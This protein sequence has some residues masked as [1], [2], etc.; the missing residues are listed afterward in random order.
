MSRRPRVRLHV[1]PFKKTYLEPVKIPDWHHIYADPSRP[2][3]VDLGSARGRFLW[4]MAQERPEWNY[5]GLEIRK[6]LIEEANAWRD[7]DQLTNLHYLFCNVTHALDE[8]LAS[9]PEGTLREITILYPDPWFK[10]KHHKRRMVQPEV[11]NTI[12]RYLPVEGKV[13]LMSDVEEV[14]QY[15]ANLFEK[16]PA[17]LRKQPLWLPENP[18]PVASEREV[19]ALRLGR[20]VYRTF[21]VRTFPYTSDAPHYTHQ[22]LSSGS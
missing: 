3:L 22:M 20:P 15:M 8:V 12:A 14:A 18:L 4:R 7:R 16:H 6:A 10:K 11:V 19:A 21:F 17:F 13:Y 5:L 9:L 2:L 1:N